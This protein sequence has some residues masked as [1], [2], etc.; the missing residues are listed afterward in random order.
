MHG[1]GNTG[2]KMSHQS[3][4]GLNGSVEVNNTL[5]NAHL[6]AVEGVGSLGRV[7]QVQ[8]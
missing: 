5:V 4:D 1:Q 8:C 6:V 3:A 7:K 2:I